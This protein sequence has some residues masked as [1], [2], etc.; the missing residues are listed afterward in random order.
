MHGI[1][2]WVLFYSVIPSIHDIFMSN[3]SF[4]WHLNSSQT[5]DLTRNCISPILHL[6]RLFLLFLD[7]LFQ[8]NLPITM[9]SYSIFWYKG[10]K[11][12]KLDSF[13]PENKVNSTKKN[14]FFKLLWS[15]FLSP[16]SSFPLLQP[17]CYSFELLLMQVVF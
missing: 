7:D 16:A 14:R 12:N 4:H 13:Q 1:K 2:W 11:E 8:F 3:A 10:S 17:L 9:L 15:F 6:Q 5:T